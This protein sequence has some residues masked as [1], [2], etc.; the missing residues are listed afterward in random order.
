MARDDGHV[1]GRV[2]AAELGD[3]SADSSPSA[4]AKA[5]TTALEDAQA[6][7]EDDG[8]AEARFAAALA[9][10]GLLLPFPHFHNPHR[11]HV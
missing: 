8:D 1:A 4:D 5:E 10:S 6:G 3:H 9:S 7:W 2:L 11:L